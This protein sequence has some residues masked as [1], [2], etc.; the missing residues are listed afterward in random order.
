MD[1]RSRG[2]NRFNSKKSGGVGS[3]FQNVTANSKIAMVNN[4]LGNRSLK[5]NQGSS[6]EVY[7]YITQTA[8]TIGTSQ[9]LTFFSNVNTKNFPLTNVQQNQLQVGE[10]L[11]VEYIAFTRIS[12]VTATGSI[13]ECTALVTTV[14]GMNLGQFSF[15]LDNSRIIKINSLIRTN[16][17]FNPKGTTGVSNLYFPDTDL[18]I[19]PQISYT[20]ELRTPVNNDTIAA[21]TTISYGCHLFGTGSILNLKTN[22]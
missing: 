22:V 8:G 6:V 13:T 11:S 5:R 12:Q 4:A 21:G 9:T 20:L 15:N 10:S 2:A 7:D 3:P 17:V 19:P 16:S 14:G 1:L 18:V